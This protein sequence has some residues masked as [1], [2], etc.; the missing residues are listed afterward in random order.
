M[1]SEVANNDADLT[2]DS[3][4][5]NKED[6]DMN[7]SEKEEQKTLDYKEAL[8][9]Y[10]KNINKNINTIWRPIYKVIDITFF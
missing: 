10:V 3:G 1:V 6:D 2:K 8:K 5:T 7:I 4:K 9:I